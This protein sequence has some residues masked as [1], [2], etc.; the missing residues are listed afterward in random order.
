M[1]NGLISV[2]GLLASCHSS[3][4]QHKAWDKMVA[5]GVPELPLVD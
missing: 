5:L 3:I 4:L 2:L 1:K